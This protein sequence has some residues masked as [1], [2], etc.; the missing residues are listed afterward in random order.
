MRDE[1][2]LRTR[3]AIFV[4]LGVIGPAVLLVGL[5]YFLD[6]AHTDELLQ[7]RTETQAKVLAAGLSLPLWNLDTPAIQE[8]LD[9]FRSDRNFFHIEVAD[10]ERSFV[11]KNNPFDHEINKVF[12]AHAD[13]QHNKKAIGQVEVTLTDAPDHQA[14]L[15][16]MREYLVLVLIQSVLSFFI[17]MYVMARRVHGPIER[18]VDEAGRM[19]QGELG[20]PVQEEQGIEFG[21][22][23][24]ALDVMRHSMK[25]SLGE[26]DA[27]VE[28][29]TRALK[30]AMR[31]LVESE[32]LVAL[33]SIVAGV[34]HELNTPLGNVLM[35]ASTLRE[36]I[37]LLAVD[38]RRGA[39]RR[40]TIERFVSEAEDASALILKST[41]RA[42]KLVTQFK[43]VATD[44]ASN[45]RMN[46]DLAEVIDSAVASLRPSLR[47]TN[48]SVGMEIPPGIRV[49]SYPGALE[50][51]VINII[52]N[53]VTHAFAGNIGSVRVTALPPTD[54]RVK[55]TISDDGIGMTAEV[56]A[57]IF[58][59]FFTT[60]LGQGGSGLGLYI[61][62]NLVTGILGGELTVGTAAGQG[63]R[64]YI[65]MP[66]SAPRDP[67]PDQ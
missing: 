39:L 33:G 20:Q 53:A 63:S 60:K 37:E 34:A 14:L 10:Q 61:V 41:E 62:H 52:M 11:V 5:N 49:D 1:I 51:V 15:E 28:E 4:L 55:L 45:R 27:Q 46:F 25:R 50:Q 22:L 65:E 54:G 40:S 7:E 31:Q 59:P 35:V 36:R 8:Q 48:V 38:Y 57:R 29:R 13:V 24:R 67:L 18:L 3:V 47:H 56:Q 66:V 32:K 19:A 6:T 64:F 44:Q 30:R 26:L 2:S 21:R 23:A 9:A 16:R 42:A 17:I 43:G 58:E 12:R